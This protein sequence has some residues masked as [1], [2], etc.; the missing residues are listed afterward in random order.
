MKQPGSGMHPQTAGAATVRKIAIKGDWEPPAKA[1]TALQTGH[2]GLSIT[3]HKPNT[4][5]TARISICTVKPAIRGLAKMFCNFRRRVFHVT[6][7]MMYTVVILA[8]I[9]KGAIPRNRFMRS[10]GAGDDFCSFPVFDHAVLDCADHDF[11]AGF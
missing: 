8:E 3:I 9:V 10:T 5:S 7:A 11:P 4:H 2:S 6:G 1:V